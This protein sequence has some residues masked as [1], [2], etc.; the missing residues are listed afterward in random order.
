MEFSLKRSA[1]I[2]SF[3]YATA[4]PHYQRSWPPTL[5]LYMFSVAH[6]PKNYFWPKPKHSAYFLKSY[7]K[8]TFKAVKN[9]NVMLFL[10][11]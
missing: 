1:D 9:F 5:D 7:I 3:K 8:R 2:Q 6:A 11:F 4:Q 10:P